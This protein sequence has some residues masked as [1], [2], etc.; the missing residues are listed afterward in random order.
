[1][2]GDFCIG[3]VLTQS[4]NEQ[5]RPPHLFSSRSTVANMHEGATRQTINCLKRPS[6]TRLFAH[7]SRELVRNELRAIVSPRFPQRRSEL[8]LDQELYCRIR[9]LQTHR[10][11]SYQSGLR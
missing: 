11:E 1:M 8:N 3:R 6:S 4:R 5:A 7:N 10:R 9:E 2:A